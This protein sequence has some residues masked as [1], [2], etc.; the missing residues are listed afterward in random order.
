MDNQLV[1]II[2]PCYNGGKVICRYLDSVLNQ[3]YRNIELVFVNDGSTDNTEEVVLKY[4]S[5]FEKS[6]MKLIYIKQENKG[7]G[8]AIDTGLKY[9][10]GDFLCWAD[11]DDFF[12]SESVE[13]RVEFLNKNLQYGCVT[14]NAYVYDE[15]N[16]DIPLY[17]VGDRSSDNKC[18]D[19]FEYHLRAKSIF[20]CGCHMI[21][22]EAFLDVNPN[23]EIFPAKRGQ[24][25]Q[26]LLPVYYK[27]KRGFLDECLYNYIIYKSSMSSLDTS[28]EERVRRF[29]EH[30]EIIENTLYRINMSNYE[31]EKY[32]KIFYNICIV[33]IFDV[34]IIYT[35][36]KLALKQYFKMVKYRLL[37]KNDTKSLVKIIINSLIN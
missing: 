21:R 19:Q 15:C 7:L 35:D 23:R 36:I 11:A 16:L 10:T 31:R 5:S 22:S 37:R 26:M 27:Y 20:C 13:K 17:K 2:T 34:S 24:N 6:G 18:E 4:K 8:G 25:W 28:K 33:D 30:Y 1:S 14:S 29:N 32:L 3:T 9:F 12:H